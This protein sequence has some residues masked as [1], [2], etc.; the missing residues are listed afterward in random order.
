[1]N[2]VINEIC[3]VLV[4]SEE[5][6]HTLCA[7]HPAWPTMP[8]LKSMMTKDPAIRKMIED[9]SKKQLLNLLLKSEKV[10]DLLTESEERDTYSFDDDDTIHWHTPKLDEASKLQRY[11]ISQYEK[12]ERQWN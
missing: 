4:K 1:M 6:I 3:N 8:E 2:V 12:L 7:A 9:A 5:D 11:Y 10:M